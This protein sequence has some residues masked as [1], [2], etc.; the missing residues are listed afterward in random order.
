MIHEVSGVKICR[1]TY[2]IRAGKLYKNE[3]TSYL[4][5]KTDISELEMTGHLFI[6][7]DEDIIFAQ[8][9]DLKYYEY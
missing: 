9:I 8:N 7:T 2:N 1:D 4:I 5:E 3:N 6:D